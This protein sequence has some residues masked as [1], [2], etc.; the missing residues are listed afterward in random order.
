MLDIK[1]LPH[2][3][4]LK[5]ID[6]FEKGAVLFNRN[7]KAIIFNETIQNLFPA[8]Q[9]DGRFFAE[10]TL[11]TQKRSS[12]RFDLEAWLAS[13][14]NT[15]QQKV[16]SS[17]LWL[18]SPNSRLPMPVTLE[19]HQIDFNQNPHILLM[20]SDKS[21]ERQF[22]AH[23][24]LM[25]VTYSGQFITNAGGYIVQPNN[26][27][28]GYTGL[29]TSELQAMTYIE[30]LK[31]QV[32]FNVPF[33]QVMNAL[34]KEH[35]WTGEV[36][37][38]P[39]NE[40]QFSAILNISMLVDKQNNIEH[41]IGVIEDQTDLEEAQ[42]EINKLS[43]YDQ[44]TGLA[45]RNQLNT[46]IE[47]TLKTLT[48]DHQ[49][50]ALLYVGL[51]GFKIINDT[52]GHKVGDQLLVQASERIK[53]TLGTNIHT[54]RLDGSNFAVLHHSDYEDR[55]LALEELW[56]TANKLLETIDGRYKLND[57]SI[58]SS[59]SIGACLFPFEDIDKYATD[60]LT[61][62]A[63]MAMHEARKKG[64]NQVYLFDKSLVEKAQSRLQLIE[65][66]NHSELDN[67]FQIYFQ[68][69]V[70]NTGKVISAE[71]LIR[72]HHPDMGVVPPSKFIPVAEE[73]RQII[74]IGLWVL[75]KAF[76]QV[77]A[78]NKSDP[79]FRAAINISPVQFHEQSFVEIIIGLVK[80][81]QVNPVNITL[82][83]TEGVLI[84]NAKL[85]L[86]KIQHLVSLG[87]EIS[88]DDFGTGYSSLSYL[89]K[90][91]IHELKIDQS[92]T[93]HLQEDSDEAAIVDSIIQLAQSK[94]L[95]LVAEGVETKH[96]TDY[97]IEKD[98]NILLQD[99]YFDKP[100]PAE[101]FEKRHI[102]LAP[103]VANL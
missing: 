54:Y 85:A 91:P 55:I 12:K 62:F 79:G 81:T 38:F 87:F 83:L 60:Q 1:A 57:N 31:R 102:K 4:S 52:F 74:K 80:F 97:L 7:G 37:I 27:F 84:K 10:F 93:C 11:Y 69:Q 44:L 13:F 100:Q 42:T 21:L 32:S 19:L 20:V 53:Q 88:I 50:H 48:N 101:E 70:D 15:H 16:K 49:F 22:C 40:T 78:W 56:A 41:F 103:E 71:T 25:N 43:Y 90:L 34:L 30:W 99:Y 24:K 51:D 68:P 39:N 29:G 5:I 63:D 82:E 9:P 65:A 8:L 45:N 92:F 75:H 72:W 64:G 67:E 17:Q 14:D 61:S 23:R 95:K 89:Q 66:L 47:T 36:Q 26:A 76:L 58:H 94:K 73:E 46:E 98:S 18:K 59:A 6:H 96:Q 77:K 3:D 33:D 28:L 35:F 2:L 86:Q